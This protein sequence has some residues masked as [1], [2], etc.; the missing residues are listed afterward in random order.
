MLMCVTIVTRNSRFIFGFL[1]LE[2]TQ[3][4]QQLLD[5]IV[6]YLLDHG[7]LNLSLRPLATAL[8]TNARMLLYYFGSKDALIASV[9]ADV[10]ALQKTAI[11]TWLA[12]TP[13]SESVAT[14][15]HNFWRWLT[16]EPLH[17]AL[18]LYFEIGTL[19][20]RHIEPYHSFC[21]QIATECASALRPQ[22]QKAGILPEQLDVTTTLVLSAV[23]GLL[24]DLLTNGERERVDQ[25]FGLLVHFTLPPE[26]AHTSEGN[27]Q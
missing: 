17:P 4:K 12:Q 22:L 3:R 5:H 20:L 14:Q 19:G 13:R 24:R 21:Q 6:I 18:R 1:M 16:T 7:L 23:E 10:A 27:K 8:E 15:M 9:L 26:V 11:D 25:A 2:D